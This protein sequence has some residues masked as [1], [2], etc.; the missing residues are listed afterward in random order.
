MTLPQLIDA[1]LVRMS[2][3]R[4]EAQAAFEHALIQE[5]AYRSL[6]RS[7]RRVLHGIVAGVLERLQ[8]GKPAELLPTL[9]LHYDRAGEVE[10]AR[11]Y[12]T[13]AG[14]LAAD[15]FAYAEAK[16]L[17]ERARE[18]SGESPVTAAELT[19]IYSGLGLV[20]EVTGDFPAALAAYD[21]LRRL[22]HARNEPGITL[23]ALMALAKIRSTPN[24]EQDPTAAAGLLED[25][26]RLA[27]DLGDRTSESRILWNRM[28]LAVYSG[29]DVDSA[30]RDGNA[31]LSLAEEL[32]DDEQIAFTLNDLGYAYTAADLPEEAL[33]SLQKAA[34]LWRRLDNRP[35]LADGLAASVPPFYALGRLREAVSAADDSLQVARSIDNLWGMANSRFFVTYALFDLGR[36]DE[37][38]QAVVQG[39]QWAEASGHVV[40]RYVGKADLGWILGSLGDVEEGLRLAEGVLDLLP[41]VFSHLVLPHV[42]GLL[43]RLLL[44]TGRIDRARQEWEHGARLIPEQGL[45]LLGRVYLGLASAEIDLADGNSAQALVSLKQLGESLQSKGTVVH[46]PE[47]LHLTSMAHRR[48]GRIGEAIE[49]ADRGLEKARELSLLRM[50]GPLADDLA[51]AHAAAGD[52]RRAAE[53]RLQAREAAETL[54]ARIPDAQLRERFLR[55]DWVR[56]SMRP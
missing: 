21:E 5:A 2:D 11:R 4:L 18:L 49:A 24:P 51:G 52:E 23:Q 35:M 45:R 41:P 46:L 43:A 19:E 6:L 1:G 54:A 38:M 29:G 44:R 34:E 22:G 48:E 39:N 37:A 33:A 14:R 17:L 27:K 40:V 42:H 47:I 15:R 3:D 32:R 31:S 56:A 10:P 50:A 55:L 12:A 25:S 20:L 16:T 13:M 26:L 30:I 8:P 53:A 36:P 28:I 9:A 7:E